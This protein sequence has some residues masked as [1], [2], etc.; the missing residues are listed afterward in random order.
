VAFETIPTRG[1]RLGL[2]T[3]LRKENHAWWGT[4]RWWMQALI[5]LLG[6]NGLVAFVSF[7]LPFMV[8]Q[9]QGELPQDFDPL[10][11]GIQTFFQLG[12]LGMAVGA[13]VLTQGVMQDELRSG[14]AAW[15]LSK[16]VSRAA[17]VLSKLIAYGMG[18][19]AVVVGLQSVMA[20]GLLSL[21]AGALLPIGPF[22][23]A[24]S[25]L[26]LHTL[27]CLALTV[28]L[29]VWS[30]SRGIVLGG[31][32][33]C[34][35]GGSILASLVPPLAVLPPWSMA[36]LL[37]ALAAGQAPPRAWVGLS[38]AAMAALIVVS[39]ILAIVKFQRI[40]F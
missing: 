20:Y 35:L 17:F 11:V 7:V 27:F 15:V 8:I 14:T 26:A 6:I 9:M 19:L 21:R 24:V 37:P 25:G 33:G 4:R 40:E 18:L 36:G 32:L 29:G 12:T 16:P 5:W 23:A 2:R 28:L 38:M 31:S 39:V 22:A 13:V 34:L 1:W 30:E 3:L 10:I